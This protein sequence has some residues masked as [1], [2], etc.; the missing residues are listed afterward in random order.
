M[1]NKLFLLVSL[2]LFLSFCIPFGASA[3]VVVLKNQ[4]QTKLE[5]HPLSFTQ[6]QI[7]NTLS[8]I[9]KIHPISFENRNFIRLQ[10]PGYMQSKQIGAP[11]LPIKTEI[12]EIPYGSTLHIKIT[13]KAYQEVSLKALGYTEAIMPVQA[14]IS[15][16]ASTAP[17]FRYQEKIYKKNKY[18]DTPLVSVEYLGE[19]RGVSYARITIAPVQYNPVKKSLRI[20]H[21]LNFTIDFKNADEVR[22]MTRKQQYASPEFKGLQGQAINNLS[23][24]STQVQ[25]ANNARKGNAD[26]TYPANNV[27]RYVIISDTL[28]AQ[29]LQPFIAWKQQQGFDVHTAYTSNAQVGKTTQS[30]KAYL[31]NLYD[32]PTAYQA[33]PSYVLLVGDIAQ[34]PSFN[35]TLPESVD[36][37]YSINHVTDL[38]YAEYTGDYL[39]D[40]HYGR[41]SASTVAQ[42]LPQIEKTLKMEQL[43]L[44]STQFMDTTVLIAGYDKSWGFRLLNKQLDYGCIN[45]FNANQGIQAKSY[46]YPESSSQANEIIADINKGAC[47]VSYTAHG[48]W[49]CWADPLISV[50]E[51]KT[52]L[53]NL[54]KYPLIIGNCCLSGKFDKP[55]CFGEALLRA[56]KKG[57]VAY[58]GA[59]NSSYFVED[60]CWAVGAVDGTQFPDTVDMQNITY[61]TTDL[62]VY[63]KLFHT[64]GEDVNQWIHT[65][66]E[67]VTQGNLTVMAAASVLEDY[68]WEIYHVFGDPSYRIQVRNPDSLKV[69]HPK[70]ILPGSTQIDIQTEAYAGV[71]IHQDSLLL[72]YGVADSTGALTLPLELKSMQPLNLRVWAQFKKD[73]VQQLPIRSPE[74][75]YVFIADKEVKNTEKINQ[76]RIFYN[77]TYTVDVELQN[78]GQT[79]ANAVKVELIPVDSN[80]LLVMGQSEVLPT[81]NAGASSSI[82]E[83]LKFKVLPNIHDSIAVSL[84]IRVSSQGQIPFEQKLAFLAS[85]PALEVLSI[86]IQDS[87]SRKPNGKLDANETV[88]AQVVFQNRGS[89]LLSN[90]H[91]TISSPQTYILPSK[92]QFSLGDMAVGETKMISF[93]LQATNQATEFALYTLDFTAHSLEREEVF[94][95]K[96]SISLVSEDFESG[97]LSRM[98]WD[99][100]ASTWSVV[101]DPASFEGDYCAKSASIKRNDSSHLI[102]HSNSLINDSISFYYK[103]AS[104]LRD[105]YGDFFQFYINDVLM[106]TYAGLIPWT[107]VA[108]PVKKGAN[109]FRWTYLKDDSDEQYKDCAW[110]DNI[111]FPLGTPRLAANEN[112]PKWE[113]LQ[114]ADQWMAFVN[115]SGEIELNFTLTHPWKG[116]I[117]L[118][119][120]SGRKIAVLAQNVHIPLG[121]TVLHFASP[122]LSKSLYFCVFESERERRVQ[123]IVIVK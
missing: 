117:S 27:L 50:S 18:N 42:L 31:K 105:G 69:E 51:I 94:S 110:V 90:A 121:R 12:I 66:S 108:F 24:V 74:G 4:A 52:Q 6:L 41:F 13:E 88:M 119:D 83:Q 20:Y 84:K 97:S 8:A 38:Y 19:M 63:D 32:H 71:C 11:A 76:N 107:R 29:A 9:D 81:L 111:N 75:A 17:L 54:N 53:H 28:F 15:K 92:E 73:Y 95:C 3:Q 98:E 43:D 102:I 106:C 115:Q 60:F 36:G 123:K 101:K 70:D 14:P 62:G 77:D 56:D 7:K 118:M 93:T 44:P 87:A 103:V 26:Y 16:S 58:I 79:S 68:Y 100:L 21:T 39:P 113:I 120:F 30:I 2:F 64:H 40:A 49:D 86:R 55:E 82:K 25:T 23:E 99:T 72:A 34:I 37:F 78:M 61:E 85:A 116:S 10:I 33:A 104:E 35:S 22:S 67:M 65:A 46:R 91:I 48:D 5:V 59:S 96:E 80:L 45:Y 1:K 114:N 112:E 122:K 109:T 47:L 89:V 57:A